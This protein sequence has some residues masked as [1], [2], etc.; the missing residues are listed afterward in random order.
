MRFKE[1]PKRW[2]TQIIILSSISV[3]FFVL[4]IIFNL[5][6]NTYRAENEKQRTKLVKNDSEL[7][8]ERIEI[9]RDGKDS[10]KANLYVPD[11]IGDE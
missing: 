10:V 9:P 3:L 6:L 2:K 1:L 4:L 8:G 11:T 7:I 5:F